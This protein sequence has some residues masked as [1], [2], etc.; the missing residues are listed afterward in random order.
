MPYVIKVVLS[1]IIIVSVSEI[2][3]RVCWIAAIVASLP[4]V[5]ILALIWLY[6]DTHDVQKITER[7]LELAT[8]IDKIY[9]A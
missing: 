6:I 3:K 5:S 8:Q 2:A 7:D 9:S 4:L 1:S